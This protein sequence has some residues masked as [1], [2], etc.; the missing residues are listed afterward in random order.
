MDQPLDQ[1]LVEAGAIRLRPILM[2]TLTTIISM[3]PNALAYGDA[4]AMM[5]DLALVNVGGLSAATLLTLLLLPTFYR[6][7]DK[8]GK[9]RYNQYAEL[10]C[11]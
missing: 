1:A 9:S 2:T 5:Q 3:M 7:V 4:G 11:D 10:D 8:M 6:L